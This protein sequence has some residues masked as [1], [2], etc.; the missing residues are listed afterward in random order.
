[1]FIKQNTTTKVVNTANKSLKQYSY[2]ERLIALP[3]EDYGTDVQAG[4][5]AKGYT[6]IADNGSVRTYTGLPGYAYVVL[7]EQPTTDYLICCETEHAY[8]QWMRKYSMVTHLI[9]KFLP[10][11]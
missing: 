11:Q 7:I 6:L 2:K 8:V 3:S 5:E 10:K 4:L 1:M 9:E